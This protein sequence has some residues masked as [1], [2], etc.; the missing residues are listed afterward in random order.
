MR[1]DR[2]GAALWFGELMT[3]VSAVGGVRS[4][5][6]GVLIWSGIQTDV[7]PRNCIPSMD[8][9]YCFW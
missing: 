5:D 3:G 1:L 7:G 9:S 4:H 8:Y 2:T 6:R